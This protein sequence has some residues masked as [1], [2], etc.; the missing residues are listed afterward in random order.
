M[1][2]PLT[3]PTWTPTQAAALHGIRTAIGVFKP[4]FGQA[5]S[6]AERAQVPIEGIPEGIH[7]PCELAPVPIF[8]YTDAP[9]EPFADVKK[10]V[11]VIL[12]VHGGGNV[13]GHPTEK[14][15]MSFFSRILLAL[16]RKSGAGGPSAPIIAAPC[17]RLAT[18]PEN[19]FPAALHV[20]TRARSK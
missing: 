17:R 20:R 15:F 3:R 9:S 5:Q 1:S 8:F 6:L 10:D 7:I 19:L 13:S 4:T 18:V 16:G 2:S 14:R 12:H 11:K